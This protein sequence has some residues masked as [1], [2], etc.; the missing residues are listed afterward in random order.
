MDASPS[1]ISETLELVLAVSRLRELLPERLRACKEPQDIIALLED[2]D[3]GPL[4]AASFAEALG[5]IEEAMQLAPVEIVPVILMPSSQDRRSEV[6][7]ELVRLLRAEHQP[8]FLVEFPA[9]PPPGCTFTRLVWF[10]P[11][12]ETLPN[13]AFDAFHR[14]RQI[15]PYARVVCPSDTSPTHEERNLL[16]KVGFFARARFVEISPEAK[17]AAQNILTA[18]KTN[19]EDHRPGA[20]PVN[21]SADVSDDHLGIASDA[22]AFARI[23]ADRTLAPPLAIAVFGNWGSGKSVFMRLIERRLKDLDGST[24]STTY[25]AAKTRC[26]WF[27]AWHYVEADL[28]ASLAATIFD[29]LHLEPSEKQP[30]PAERRA[31]ILGQMEIARLSVASLEKEK[32][33]EIARLEIRREELARSKTQNALQLGDLRTG[34]QSM[35]DHLGRHFSSDVHLAPADREQLDQAR[36]MA[37]DVVADAQTLAAE[38]RALG[39]SAGML[40]QTWGEIRRNWKLY[41]GAFGLTLSVALLSLLT[42]LFSE[43]LGKLGSRIVAAGA[44]VTPALVAAGKAV[45]KLAKAKK[46]YREILDR[47]RKELEAQQAEKY[48]IE[49]SRLEE[50]ETRLATEKAVL[51]RLR[52]ERAGTF[53]AAQLKD[54]IA[55]RAT[56]NDYKAGLGLLAALRKDCEKL[57]ELLAKQS[58]DQTESDAPKAEL[59]RIVLFID[60]LDRC[61]PDRVVEVLQAVHLLLAFPLFVVVVGVDARWVSGCLQ[62][63][64]TDT[65]GPDPKQH[66]TRPGDY[67]EKIFQIPYWLAPFSREPAD[68]Y[69]R[70]LVRASGAVIAGS[71]SESAGTGASTRPAAR[72]SGASQSTPSDAD[73][74]NALPWAPRELDVVASLSSIPGSTPRATKRFFNLYNLLR[75]HPLLWPAIAR[76]LEGGAD[77]TFAACAV[78]LAISNSGE[79]TAKSL[80]PLLGEIEQ[81][82]PPPPTLPRDRRVQDLNLNVETSWEALCNSPER[83]AI[84]ELALRLSFHGHL[85]ES[86]SENRR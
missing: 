48:R 1:A 23:I 47:K 9:P 72:S 25:S 56:A 11:V 75:H 36:R 5:K 67:L 70:T 13:A 4:L 46:I 71:A 30:G 43:E 77:Q 78:A 53:T 19:E 50:I 66:I 74:T 31:K 29:C 2:S 52:T 51:A 69:F 24:N 60:D 85:L 76:N 15:A 17:E 40:R 44:I 64:F 18:F 33:E 14:W 73:S 37:N 58:I 41:A 65:I 59:E 54:F 39:E 20:R 22:G 32:S 26:V 3:T 12:Y 79:S 16:R 10:D 21:D 84:I 7:S 57:S 81:E 83:A 35:L 6:A 42:P 63:R 45:A 8:A 34:I 82:Y 38:W 28:W 80:L 27:N 86:F 68:T 62:R 61:P 55:S 49:Q